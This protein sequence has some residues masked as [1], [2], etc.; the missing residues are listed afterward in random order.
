MAA[1]C[2]F[3]VESGKLM[4][5]STFGFQ[6][7]IGSS[8][9]LWYTVGKI[10]DKNLEKQINIK[11]CVKIGKSASETLVLLTVAYGEYAVKKSSVFEWRRRSGKGEKV[12]KMTQEV[13]SQKPK[14]QMQMWTDYEP[15]CAQ[16]ED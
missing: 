2:R 1:A 5:P 16:I 12:C 4:Y 7:S 6:S 13:S 14:G 15:W 11:F 8:T 10:S 9:C 3:G